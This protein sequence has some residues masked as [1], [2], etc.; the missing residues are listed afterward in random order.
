M[1]PGTAPSALATTGHQPLLQSKGDPDA[2]RK[3]VKVRRPQP[4]ASVVMGMGGRPLSG[5]AQQEGAHGSLWVGLSL[6]KSVWE[7]MK[8]V[9]LTN[10]GHTEGLSNLDS[11]SDKFKCLKTQ[12]LPNA[13]PWTGCWD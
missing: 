13:R 1:S 7:G 4:R 9:A 5:T 11:N 8:A 10:E 3:P 2:G 6:G 12:P